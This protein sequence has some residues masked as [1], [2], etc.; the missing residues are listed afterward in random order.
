[1]N[2]A[3]DKKIVDMIKI[4]NGSIVDKEL[5]PGKKN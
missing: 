3:R 5:W 4:V 2:E 1:M